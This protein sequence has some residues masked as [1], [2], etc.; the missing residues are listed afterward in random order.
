MTRQISKANFSRSDSSF[1]HQN[2][3]RSAVYCRFAGIILLLSFIFVSGCSQQDRDA[4]GPASPAQ[5]QHFAVRGIVRE[6]KPDGKT[7]VIAHEEIPGYMEAMTMPFRVKDT[8][9]LAKVTVGDQVTFRLVVT[10]DDGWIEGLEKKGANLDLPPSRDL[11]REVREV[12]PLKVGDPLPNYRFTNQLGQVVAMND[13]RGKALAFTFI[14]TRCPFPTFC[15]RMNTHF[16]EAHRR[17][18]ALPDLAGKWH[19]LTISF[20][21]QFDTPAVLKKYAENHRY[22][23]GKHWSFLTGALVDMDALTEQFG[24]YFSRDGAQGITFNHNLRTV[25]VNP[26]GKVQQVFSGNEWTVE[27]LVA[28][29]T[30]A[31]QAAGLSQ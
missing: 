17:L 27:D 14:F 6:I 16:A 11:F 28:E 29:M 1:L 18:A 21:P 2:V 31:A 24:L 10:Q 8:N 4:H 30:R 9:E 12:D 13:F 25:V 7:A 3:K 5:S 26:G 20:D 15:P 23:A 19:F 22:E